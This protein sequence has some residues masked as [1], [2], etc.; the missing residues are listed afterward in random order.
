MLTLAG[1]KIVSEVLAPVREMSFILVVTFCANRGGTIKTAANA[2]RMRLL[3]GSRICKVE[4]PKF[5]CLFETKENNHMA[6]TLPNMNNR[7]NT[8]VF[9]NSEARKSS[10]GQSRTLAD[11]PEAV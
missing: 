3:R 2:S 1:V 11:D 8:L 7:S 5:T 9:Q 4:S 10:V 6:E